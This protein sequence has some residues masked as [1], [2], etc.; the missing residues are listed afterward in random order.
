MQTIIQIS[1]KYIIFLM[2]L[3]AFKIIKQDENK[4]KNKEEEVKI[5]YYIR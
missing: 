3:R 2:V 5:F 4:N 1:S